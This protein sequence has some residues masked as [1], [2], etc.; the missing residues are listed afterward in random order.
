MIQ[1]AL[2]NVLKEKGRSV[3]WLAKKSKVSYNQLLKLAKAEVSAVTFH[4]L[5]QLCAVLDC[6]PGDIIEYCKPT[7]PPNRVS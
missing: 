4:T 5:N 7:Q 3:Y 6:Q 2:Q 1:I